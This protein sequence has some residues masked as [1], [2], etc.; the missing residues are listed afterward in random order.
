MTR[1]QDGGA[2]IQKNDS[3]LKPPLSCFF[4]P[5]LSGR[6][7]FPRPH[8][9]KAKPMAGRQPRPGAGITVKCRG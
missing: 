7:G 4:M 3:D 8:R 6:S 9:L 5:N 2:M 1:L